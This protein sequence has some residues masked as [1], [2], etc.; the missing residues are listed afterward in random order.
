MRPERV[1]LRR[2]KDWRMPPN[3]VRCAR[4]GKH[5]NPFRVGGYFMIGDPRPG[6]HFF[7][8]S[9]C[10]SLRGPDVGF[11]LIE[12]HQQAVN[13]FRRWT[14]G[15]TDGQRES[16]RRELGGRNLACWCSPE[17]PCHT[18]VLL[19]IANGL[20]ADGA[21]LRATTTPSHSN[22]KNPQSLPTEPTNA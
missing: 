15:W 14:D 1:Q 2:T 11:T 3:T 17:R 9:Y 22:E 19:E 8:M 12:N 10:E 6:A 7:R 5:G 18:D 16:C 4:P 13:W 21:P 20:P